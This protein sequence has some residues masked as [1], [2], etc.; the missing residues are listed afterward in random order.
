[1]NFILLKA[2]LNEHKHAKMKVY[3]QVRNFNQTF[4]IFKKIKI[5]KTDLNFIL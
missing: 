2:T 3:L 5:N 4:S 1:M